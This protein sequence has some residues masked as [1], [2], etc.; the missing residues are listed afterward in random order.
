MD[1]EYCKCFVDNIIASVNTIASPL[2]DLD[3]GLRSDL[4][5]DL[6]GIIDKGKKDYP[7]FPR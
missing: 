7:V 4:D 2:L 1:S 3:S 5:D 6:I